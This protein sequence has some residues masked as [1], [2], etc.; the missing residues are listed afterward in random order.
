MVNGST[1]GH[2]K[3]LR[4]E[5]YNM[6]KDKNKKVIHIV[7]SSSNQFIEHCAS[8]MASILCNIAKDYFVIFYILSYDISKKNKVKLNKL[9]KIR[10]CKIMYPKFLMD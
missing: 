2:T 7:L 10:S 3:R 1:Y 4:V 8:T 6:D 9:C 5:G